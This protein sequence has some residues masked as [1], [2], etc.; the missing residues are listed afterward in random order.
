MQTIKL[1][2]HVGKDGIL[3]LHLPV[4]ITDTNLEITIT[5]QPATV[6]ETETPQEKGWPPGFFE[7]TFGSFKDDPILIDSEGVFDD[8]DT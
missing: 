1:H 7:E 2:S 6:I 4:G 5:V 3:H 8:W